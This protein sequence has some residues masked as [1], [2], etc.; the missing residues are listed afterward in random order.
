MPEKKHDEAIVYVFYRQNNITVGGRSLDSSYDRYD[1]EYG[2]TAEDFRRA[3]GGTD[4]IFTTVGIGA[5]SL[6]TGEHLDLGMRIKKVPNSFLGLSDEEINSG[7]QLFDGRGDVAVLHRS[8]D[9]LVDAG[10]YGIFDT[11]TGKV[12][13]YS[14]NKNHQI[15]DY[16]GR[17]VF[18]T[19][20]DGY[21]SGNKVYMVNL[22]QDAGSSLK[23]TQITD[24]ERAK[25]IL[26]KG[27]LWKRTLNPFDFEF[28]GK[29]YYVKNRMHN[30]GYLTVEDS[31]VVDDKGNEIFNAG[32][33]KNIY[34]DYLIAAIS[35]PEKPLRE[36]FEVRKDA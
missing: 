15:L 29:K 34:P 33:I 16:D 24:E 7:V 35:F 23:H 21:R 25:T 17:N 2:W 12:I 4:V 32:T 11:L 30:K 36:I 5:Y 10:R 1:V 31:R 3:R 18:F 6:N 14:P 22:D 26:Q 19:D 13:G 8:G 27:E 28:E 20:C 9:R